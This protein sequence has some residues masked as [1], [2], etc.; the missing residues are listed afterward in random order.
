MKDK[1]GVT[2]F[3]LF[4][5]CITFLR[6]NITYQGENDKVLDLFQLLSQV[7]QTE[8]DVQYVDIG[9]LDSLEKKERTIEVNHANTQSITLF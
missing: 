2:T 6:K 9:I 8:K 4:G 7:C 3:L 5:L 1:R